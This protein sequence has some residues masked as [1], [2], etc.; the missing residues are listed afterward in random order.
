MR[1]VPGFDSSKKSRQSTNTENKFL[2]RYEL[3]YNIGIARFTIS[4]YP[5]ENINTQFSKYPEKAQEPRL[6]TS[7]TK[8]K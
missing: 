2:R 7:D 6:K 5:Y 3:I 1:N 8:K 4:H